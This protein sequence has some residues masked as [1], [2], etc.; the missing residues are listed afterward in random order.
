MTLPEGYF[1]AMYRADPDPWGF[2]SRWYEQRK[3][4]LTLAALPRPRYARAFEPGCSIG[5]LSALLA[6]RCDALLSADISAGAVAAA[7]ER[8]RDRP[9]VSV[10]RRRLPHEW[11]T[12]RFDLVVLS[13]VGYYLGDD[14]LDLLLGNAV[15]SLAPGGDLVAVHWRHR[16]DDYPQ[17]GDEVHRRLA[18]DHD[19]LARTVRHEEADFLLEVYARTPPGARSVAQREGLC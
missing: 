16:V 17:L 5:V 9:Q 1:D 2:T 4:A 14:D 6:E 10:E 15:G 13:E 12:G 18:Q 3:Y 7:R 11:P 8:L 19:G